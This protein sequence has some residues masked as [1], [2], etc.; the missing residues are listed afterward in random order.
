MFRNP[1]WIIYVEVDKETKNDRFED[2]RIIRHIMDVDQGG[3][4]TG[5]TAQIQHTVY[6]AYLTLVCCGLVGAL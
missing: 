4:S 2:E 6:P 1:I 5:Q 3:L